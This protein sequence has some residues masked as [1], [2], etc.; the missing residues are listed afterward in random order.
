MLFAGDRLPR[1]CFSVRVKNTSWTHKSSWNPFQSQSPWRCTPQTRQCFKCPLCVVATRRVF[2]HKKI[3]ATK[4]LWRHFL[5]SKIVFW[6]SSIWIRCLLNHCP[7]RPPFPL[8][9][10]FWR[11]TLWCPQAVLHFQWHL[12]LCNCH[13]FSQGSPWPF[14]LKIINYSALEGCSHLEPWATLC[15]F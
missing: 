6:K 2:S 7:Q 5:W 12:G 13:A 4:K 8:G 14:F 11:K 3:K 15:R 9:S 10:C 1:L